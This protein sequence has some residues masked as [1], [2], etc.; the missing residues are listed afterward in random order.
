MVEYHQNKQVM[1]SKMVAPVGTYSNVKDSDSVRNLQLALGIQETGN[2]DYNT[3]VAVGEFQRN[4]GW[5]GLDADGVAG[6]L[7]IKKL[8]LTWV[9]DIADE[10]GTVKVVRAAMNGVKHSYRKNWKNPSIAGKGKFTPQYVLEHHTAGTNSLANIEYGGAYHPIPK[11]NFLI[12]KKGVVYVVSAFKTY[13]A[14]YGGPYKNVPKNDMNTYSFGIEVESLGQVQDFTPEQIESVSRLTHNLLKELG[15][16]LTNVL[17][18]K[19][20]SSTGK[21]DTRY[22]DAYWVKKVG[23]IK[24]VLPPDIPDKPT[25]PPVVTSPVEPPVVIETPNVPTDTTVPSDNLV[26]STGEAM[27]PE[28]LEALIKRIVTESLSS[29][30]SKA[31]IKALILQNSFIKDYHYTDKPT[32]TQTVGTSYTKITNANYTPKSAGL[33]FSMVY[34]NVRFKFK[35]GKDTGTVRVRVVRENPNDESAYQDF[36]LTNTTTNEGEFLIT[37]VWFEECDKD[38]RLHWEIDRS[39]EFESVILNT[40]YSK[41]VLI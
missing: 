35:A 15:K 12:D 36:T 21:V 20:W 41:W 31:L 8:G 27:T 6:P 7:T 22:S 18:H 19:T 13:H 10:S 9:D 25:T 32:V 3:W 14:G 24:P 30:T 5:T 1:R 34:T 29:D 28:E 11:A 2:Y 4:Q 37:H 33:L 40:R 17:N 23:A 16:P 39:D 38:R 26:P